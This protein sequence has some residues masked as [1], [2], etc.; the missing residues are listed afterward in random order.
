MSRLIGQ[1]AETVLAGIANRLAPAGDTQ[2]AAC[3]RRAINDVFA[4]LHEKVIEAGDIA[5]LDSLDSSAID[6]AVERSIAAHIYYR[7][8]ADLGLSIEKGAISE[9]KAVDLENQMR[10]YVDDSVSLAF[11]DVDLVNADWSSGELRATINGIYEQ[12]YHILEAS[13]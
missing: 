2:E 7:W 11:E 8:L 6:A 5:A 4:G 1:D 10:K 9:S 3:A 12:A 13:E